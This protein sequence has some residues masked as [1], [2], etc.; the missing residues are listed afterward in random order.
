ME[1]EGR[2]FVTPEIDKR[3]QRRA[4]LVAQ[5]NCDALSRNE[6]LVTRDISPGGLFISTKTPLPLDSIVR[7]T[8]SLG[9]GHPNTLCSGKVVYSQQ[10][11]G[12]GIQFEELSVDDRRALE[13]FV[14]EAN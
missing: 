2:E 3:Q 10:G 5:V 11:Q 13:K 12:M 1:D 14:D 4:K 9:I 8:F 6:V 7:L